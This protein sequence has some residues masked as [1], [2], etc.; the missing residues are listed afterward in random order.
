MKGGSDLQAYNPYKRFIVLLGVLTFLGIVILS[1]TFSIL[2][3]RNILDETVQVTQEGISIHFKKVFANLFAEQHAMHGA[4]GMNNDIYS[5]QGNPAAKVLYDTQLNVVRLHFD[6]YRIEES[7]FIL[8]SGE[9]L[10]SYNRDE[11]GQR[12]PVQGELQ[13][14]F[15]NK[16]VFTRPAPEI[17]KLWIPILNE[18]GQIKEVALVER[19][20]STQLQAMRQMQL[21]GTLLV[22]TVFTVLYF[23]L[24]QVFLRSTRKINQ[25][26]QELER[27]LSALEDTY[28]ASLHALSAALDSRDNETEGHSMRVTSYTIHLARRAGVPEQDLVQIARG[29]LLHDIGKIGIPD[30][31]LRKPGALT[32][33]EWEIMKTHVTIGYEMLQPI[34]FL[35]PALPIVRS[36]HER[37]DG[38]GYP[39]GLQ[40]EEIPLPAR[41]FAICD[42]YDAITSDRPY[43]KGKSHEEAIA[44]IAAHSGTQFD[45]AIVVAF[46][47]IPQEAWLRSGQFAKERH[48]QKITIQ[49]LLEAER[50]A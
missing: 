12:V 23:S 10:F 9:I 1:G 38:K 22:A 6:L 46:L 37:W 19:N 39:M 18:A 44:E 16:V 34:E 21:I 48:E 13:Q 4:N 25:Q 7:Q 50:T 5:E 24:R 32:E 35:R 8:P 45:P 40:G 26:N 11:V 49:D 17:L 28:D 41:I 33:G 20:I 29:A 14:A 47:S 42:T 30:A 36:H 15:A 27:L 2:V 43:R 31:I 3:Q